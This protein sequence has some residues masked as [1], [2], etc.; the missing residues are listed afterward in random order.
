MR[1]HAFSGPSSTSLKAMWKRGKDKSLS[2]QDSHT[3]IVISL[4][5]LFFGGAGGTSFPGQT[6]RT[7]LYTGFLSTAHDALHAMP[8]CREA[9]EAPFPNDFTTCKALFFRNT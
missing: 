7:V 1:E 8:R 9:V 2:S 6:T 3:T 5:L 4:L